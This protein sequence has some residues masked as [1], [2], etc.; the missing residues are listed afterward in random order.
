[1]ARSTRRRT[2]GC[3]PTPDGRFVAGEVIGTEGPSVRA[4]WHSAVSNES[5]VL[6]LRRSAGGARDRRWACVQENCREEDAADWPFSGPRT[7]TWC[8]QF[9]R[10]ENRTLELHHERFRALA[11]DDGAAWGIAEHKEVC[12]FLTL[13]A[14]YDQIDVVNRAAAESLFRRLQ[15]YEFSHA[16]KIRE[17]ETKNSGGSRLSAEEQAIFGGMARTDA[18]LL[19][20]PRL[21]EYALAEVERSASLAKNLRR[22]GEEREAVKKK[23]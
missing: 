13:L 10:R 15:T 2:E 17:A 21:L 19:I 14:L 8:L 12:G 22:E 3:W 18:A 1:M 4:F 5:R 11:L 6:P 7:V 9:I 16:E 23:W 20:A